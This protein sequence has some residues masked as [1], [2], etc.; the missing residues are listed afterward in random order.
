MRPYELLDLEC[1]TNYKSAFIKLCII[2][3]KQKYLNQL[4]LQIISD[5]KISPEDLFDSIK[6]ED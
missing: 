1:V 3:Y 5:N 6:M 4:E 2:L